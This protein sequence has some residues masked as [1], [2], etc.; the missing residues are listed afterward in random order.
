MPSH[1]VHSSHPASHDEDAIRIKREPP[2]IWLGRLTWVIMLIVMLEYA[3]GSHQEREPQAAITAFA[4]FLIMLLAWVIVEVVRYVESQPESR[5]LRDMA[6]ANGAA[7]RDSD[8]DGAFEL[9]RDMVQTPVTD[10]APNDHTL[11]DIDANMDQK[12]VLYE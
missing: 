1:D 7:A 9:P 3:I 8:F 2:H 4:L 12:D 11:P 10:A 5:M 6:R